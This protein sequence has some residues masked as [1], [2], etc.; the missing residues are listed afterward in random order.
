M[1]P[2]SFVY[3][4]V[5]VRYVSGRGWLYILSPDGNEAVRGEFKPTAAAAFD[6]GLAL[7]AREWRAKP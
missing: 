5:T 6:A 4:D 1:K 7:A 2:P 3:F